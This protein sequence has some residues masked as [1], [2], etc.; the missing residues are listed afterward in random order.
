MD[1]QNCVIAEVKDFIKQFHDGDLIITPEDRNFEMTYPEKS[2]LGLTSAYRKNFAD[3]LGW[4]IAAYQ[5]QKDVSPKTGLEIAYELL[6][7]V[8]QARAFG[9]IKPQKLTNQL[10][11]CQEQNQ[12]PKERVDK[13]EKEV[14]K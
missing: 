3:S 11:E 13:L 1:E 7:L 8:E 9:I 12:H 4:A 14:L 2:A 5:L 10:K 6:D